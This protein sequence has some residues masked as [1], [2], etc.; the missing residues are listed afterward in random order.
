[1]RCLQSSVR[2]SSESTCGRVAVGASWT[3]GLRTV[4]AVVNVSPLNDH[5][6]G[7]LCRVFTFLAE[8]V[9]ACLHRALD[10]CCRRPTSAVQPSSPRSIV[11]D[12]RRL[13]TFAA[14]CPALT[15][16]VFRICRTS[17]VLVELLL[18]WIQVEASDILLISASNILSLDL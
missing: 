2:D 6:V 18:R 8:N 4:S 5:R 9:C 10:R 13:S 14:Q 16:D 12:G 17:S 1:M 11:A 7:P 3:Q 15:P